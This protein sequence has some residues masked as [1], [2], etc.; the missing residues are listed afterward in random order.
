VTAR[1]PGVERISHDGL[2]LRVDRVTM[3]RG[4]TVIVAVDPGDDVFLFVADGSCTVS[5][6]GSVHRLER[7]DAVD[8][9]RVDAIAIDS[10]RGAA[11][12][13]VRAARR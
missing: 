2:E 9:E 10:E 11:L 4:G 1:R 13:V 12:L 5:V 3:R 7:H 8:A 6:A